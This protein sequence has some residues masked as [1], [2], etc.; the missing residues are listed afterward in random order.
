[1]HPRSRRCQLLDYVL[2][3]RRVRVDVLVTK[4][5]RDANGWTDRH[6]VTSQ[7]RLRF[8]PRRKPQDNNATGETCWCQ[9]R[10]VIQSTALEVL[11]RAR[12]PHQD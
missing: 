6:L 2:V 11:G 5:I 7:M 4:A 12:R 3:Q 8:K 1:M 10:N 9:L